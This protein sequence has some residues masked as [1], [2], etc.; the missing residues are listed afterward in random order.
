MEALGDEGSII[1]TATNLAELYYQIGDTERAIALIVAR[2]PL[3]RKNVDAISLMNFA[4]YLAAVRSDARARDAAREVIRYLLVSM[5]SSPFV[6]L[7]SETIALTFARDGSVERA[8]SLAGYADATLR[9]G[10]FARQ[11][12]E[13][14]TFEQLRVALAERL[15]T[16]E[17]AR[18]LD[19]GADLTAT[20]ALE[21][22]LPIVNAR[23][24]AAVSSSPGRESRCDPV[25]RYVR[26]RPD[27]RG[28]SARSE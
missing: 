8:A 11:F 17:L 24:L 28:G 16:D 5:P 27:E 13:R 25:C 26:K 14:G 9:A 20:A 10:G 19:R 4:A 3:L 21:L 7:A 23:E 1:T 15:A 2:L 22:A 18:H 12:S 6:A